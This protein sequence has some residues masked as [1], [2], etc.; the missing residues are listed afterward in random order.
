MLRPQTF[1][2]KGFNGSITLDFI[3]RFEN[4]SADFELI[5]E[6]IGIGPLSLPHELR[7]QSSNYREEYDDESMRTIQEIYSEEI[8]LFGYSFEA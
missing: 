5:C 8:E 6:R 1:W 3:G 2:L 4:L 7:G